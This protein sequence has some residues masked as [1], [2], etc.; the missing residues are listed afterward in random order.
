MK[1]VIAIV[2]LIAVVGTATFGVTG[3]R[4]EQETTIEKQ[5]EELAQQYACPMKCEGEKTYT[6]AGNC[7]ICGMALKQLE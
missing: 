3:C 2:L 5:E 7:P 1:K 4:K 6:S